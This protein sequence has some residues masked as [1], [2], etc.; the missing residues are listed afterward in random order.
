MESRTSL[1]HWNPKGIPIIVMKK[2]IPIE[3]Y[4]KA[5]SMPPKIS[6]R[7]FNS[8]FPVESE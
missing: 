5:I 8:K 4:K 6:Q 3:A 7:I 1:K 2:R